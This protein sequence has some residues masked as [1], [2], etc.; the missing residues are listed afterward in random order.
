[1]NDNK[2]NKKKK[3][4]RLN[5]GDDRDNDEIIKQQSLTLSLSLL[6]TIFWWLFRFSS[7]LMVWGYKT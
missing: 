2:A 3:K 4:K 1:M 6:S 5:T 7:C